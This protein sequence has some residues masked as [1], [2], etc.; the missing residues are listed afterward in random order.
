MYKKNTKWWNTAWTIWAHLLLLH[1]NDGKTHLL[2]PWA[3]HCSDGLPTGLFQTVPQV[4][5]RGHPEVRGNTQTQPLHQ[6]V[7]PLPACSYLSMHFYVGTSVDTCSFLSWSPTKAEETRKRFMDKV[8][9]KGKK[10][11]TSDGGCETTD[12]ISYVVVQHADHRSSFA[13][14]DGVKDLVHLWWVAHVYLENKMKMSTK[15][16]WMKS[17]ECILC[18]IST[19]ADTFTGNSFL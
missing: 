2:G 10:N 13:V 3:H 1:F 11:K 16:N 14:G 19:N 6:R 9:E 8:L 4:L 5:C 15:L 18:I 7:T 17:N 12:L